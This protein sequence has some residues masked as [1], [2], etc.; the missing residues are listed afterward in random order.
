[1]TG[2]SELRYWIGRGC[3]FVCQIIIGWG[4]NAS[5]A[6]AQASA[7]FRRVPLGCTRAVTRHRSLGREKRLDIYRRQCAAVHQRSGYSLNLCP[8]P[9]YQP[10][11]ELT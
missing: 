11:C 5:R 2:D 10:E 6:V 3:R 8:V 1:M 4:T 9:P 7:S